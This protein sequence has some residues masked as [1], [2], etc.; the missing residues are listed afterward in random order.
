SLAGLAFSRTLAGE[1]QRRYEQAAAL[2][3]GPAAAAT[4][5]RRA[6]NVAACRMRGDDA[7]RL[8]QAAADAA[9]RAADTAAAA[10]DLA[11]AA[12]T[13][14]PMSGG[15]PRLPPPHEATPL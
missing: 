8:W 6:A 3:G 10:R 14:F 5:L 15:F 9:Q 7:Y 12:A 1:A 4:A 13:Y 2:T 11:T